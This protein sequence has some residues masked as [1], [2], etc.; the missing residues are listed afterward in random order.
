[1]DLT[2]HIS[3]DGKTPKR[4]Y[5]R[6]ACERCRLRKVRWY[7]HLH[8]LMT[9]PMMFRKNATTRK[10]TDNQ[11]CLRHCGR[12]LSSFSILQLPL[13]GRDRPWVSQ[14]RSS[15]LASLRSPSYRVPS[16]PLKFTWK[17]KR[18]LRNPHGG[19]HVSTVLSVT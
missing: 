4:T 1:M 5:A 12:L 2:F 17:L 13:G 6:G 8:S 3:Q 15:F 11:G 19:I 10:Q 9:H 18:M 14:H 7:L 16:N